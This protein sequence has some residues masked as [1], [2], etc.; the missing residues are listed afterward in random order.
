MATGKVP[1]GDPSADIHYQTPAG[2]KQL[3][4]NSVR[5]ASFEV[6][7]G[8]GQ[9][10]EVAV[11]HFPGSV[12]S[13]LSNVNRWRHELNLEPIADSDISSEPVT[14]DGDSGKLYDFSSSSSRTIVADIAHNGE[15]W[16]FK[17]RG[18]KDAVTGARSAFLDFLKSVK[19]TESAGAT[20][21]VVAAAGAGGDPHAGLN[22][23]EA[24][25][26][27]TGVAS[28]SSQAETPAPASWRRKEPGPMLLRAYALGDESAPATVTVSSFP[29][30]MGG[31]L[32]NVN[33]WRRQ[34]GLG[35]ISADSL[36][37]VTQAVDANGSSATMVDFT[38]TDAQNAKPARMIAVMAPRGD[39]TWFY[40][41]LGDPATVGRER[42]SFIQYVQTARDQ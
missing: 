22:L 17:L 32:A 41:L 23:P 7:G 30:L 35:E 38:G 33:R 1:M 13:E 8:T 29:G 37:S 4:P 36:P 20:A 18:N 5:V 39:Q 11:T 3:P 14:V 28:S 40:K 31:L 2:W 19:F 25:T 27:A 24:S 42:E 10:A 9:K 6:G 16:F 15:S 12:G 26:A 34:L 21:A